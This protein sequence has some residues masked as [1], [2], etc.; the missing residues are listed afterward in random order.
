MLSACA[1]D[2]MCVVLNQSEGL[3][4]GAFRLGQL[5]QLVCVIFWLL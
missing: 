5:H 4:I 1:V 3:H 2:W